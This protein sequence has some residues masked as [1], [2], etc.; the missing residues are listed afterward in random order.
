MRKIGMLRKSV[1]ALCL[2]M[3]TGSIFLVP[4]LAYSVQENSEPSLEDMAKANNYDAT[5]VI[6]GEVLDTV[7]YYANSEAAIYTD[8]SILVNKYETGN[9]PQI[10]KVTYRGGTIG[11]KTQKCYY[12]PGGY[13][14][15]EKG[16]K[17][18][19]FAI[20]I[21]DKAGEFTTWHV[22]QTD[23]KG[24]ETQDMILLGGWG[25]ISTVLESAGLHYEFSGIHWDTDDFSL[26]YYIHSDGT[27]DCTGE[28][29]AIQA[30]FDTWENDVG[31][32]ITYNYV[33]TTTRDDVED[34]YNRS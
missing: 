5:H 7:S 34:G 31:S 32:T 20:Q 3:L 9:G 6:D 11:T 23:K 1:I 33:S 10:I 25:S 12:N 8:A 4:Q 17:I 16:Q 13:I 28:D 19:L 21:P 22:E 15:L 18:K 26:P 29:T 24:V 30:S 14:E 27:A 2:I